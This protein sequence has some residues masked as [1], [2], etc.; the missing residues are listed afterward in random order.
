MSLQTTTPPTDG[1]SMSDRTTT[2]LRRIQDLAERFH[3]HGREIEETDEFPQELHALLVD[4]DFLRM[5]LPEEWGGL[6]MSASEYIP[7]LE[8]AGQFHGAI[9]MYVH[10]M[11]GLWRP[12]WNYGTPEQQERW[13]PVHQSGGMFAFALTEASTGTGRDIGTTARLEGDRWVLDGTKNLISFASDAEVF[14]VV[15][16]TGAAE[17]GT[18]EISCILVPKGTTGVTCTPLPEGMG[19]KGTSHELVE[20][21]GATVPAENLLGERGQ[22]LEIGIR[23][24]LDI[25]RLGIATSCLAIAQRS[26]DLA[27]EFARHRVTFGKP[28]AERQAIQMQVGEMAADI[29]ALRSA[30]TSTAARFDAGRP[31]VEEAAMCK[32]LGIMT[33]TS[34]TD[35]ALNIHGGVGWTKGYEIERLYR[36]ARALWFEEGTAEIQKLV[37]SRPHLRGEV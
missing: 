2:M 34:V 18:R 12:M 3:A 4:N 8:R 26:L 19:C 37:A 15:A 33:V 7:V 16:A 17:D 24:F 35:K 30:V 1:T 27:S 31:I 10:G 22:G 29:F 25:S 14:Y 23:G 20:F 11:N 36:D 9:R 6:G 13:L 21:D 28:I 32:L 5:T